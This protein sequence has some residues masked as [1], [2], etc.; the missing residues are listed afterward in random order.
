MISAANKL[1]KKRG[2][3]QLDLTS[4][5]SWTEVE[6]SALS[7]CNTFEK[8]AAK[9]KERTPGFTGKL[10]QGFRS[11]CRNAQAGKTLLSL[12]PDGDYT[13][14]LCG[15]LRIIFTALESSDSYR[16]EIYNA[17]E[18][19][20]NQLNDH[21]ALLHLNKDDEELH[22]RSAILYAAVFKLL[23]TICS[24]LLKS[25]LGTFWDP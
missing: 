2:L 15:G 8:L 20:P 24:W 7:A 5:H 17:L 21:S 10:K 3:P 9:D 13:S 1:C 6:E 11:L 4:S 18:D 14:P 23:E 16:Q 25:K 19:L 22:R 12:V